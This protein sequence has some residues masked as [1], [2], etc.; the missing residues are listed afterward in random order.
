[1]RKPTAEGLK[2]KKNAPGSPAGIRRARPA[3]PPWR[4]SSAGASAGTARSVGDLSSRQSAAHGPREN[5]ARGGGGR[6]PGE[7]QTLWGTAHFMRWCQIYTLTVVS[8]GPP[9]KG[10]RELPERGGGRSLGDSNGGQAWSQ[11]SIRL[12]V[13]NGYPK[14]GPV[15][16]P[17]QMET[18]TRSVRSEWWWFL[19]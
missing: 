2:A 16:E 4:S 13:K 9:G 5:A 18:W 1:M 19:C 14:N 3:A 7:I 10:T 11:G 15:M 8:K 17:W 12:W 6:C